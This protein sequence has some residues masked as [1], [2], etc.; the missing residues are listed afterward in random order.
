MEDEIRLYGKKA[1][2]RGILI[3]TGITIFMGLLA[4][5]LLEA[6]DMKPGI[7]ALALLI[8]ILIVLPIRSRPIKFLVP[9]RGA[10]L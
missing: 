1:V 5:S 9:Q 8:A 7:I 10:S 2:V 3:L 6:I 4:L